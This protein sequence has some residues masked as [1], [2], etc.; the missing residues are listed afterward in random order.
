MIARRRKGA[1]G[2]HATACIRVAAVSLRAV[3][4]RSVV[5]RGIR[6]WFSGIGIARIVLGNLLELGF[7][8]NVFCR[9]G[10]FLVP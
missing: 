4:A 6:T 2:V 8:D 3:R 7:V 9:V 10:D 5:A 1:V